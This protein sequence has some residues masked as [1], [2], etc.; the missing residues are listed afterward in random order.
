MVF[1]MQN[2]EPT[3]RADSLRKSGPHFRGLVERIVMLKRV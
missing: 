3:S 2:V 1:L